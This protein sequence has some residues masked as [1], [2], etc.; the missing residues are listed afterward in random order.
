MGNLTLFLK[1][2]EHHENTTEYKVIK[3]KQGGVTKMG[4][5]KQN[6]RNQ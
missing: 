2:K 1:A 5:K 4:F 3:F 6:E